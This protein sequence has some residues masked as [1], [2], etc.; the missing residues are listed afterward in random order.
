MVATE[1]APPLEAPVPPGLEWVISRC[2]EKDPM[3][4]F[5]SMAELAASLAPFADNPVQGTRST[6]RT[7]R[8]LGMRESHE[9]LNAS[10]DSGMALRD[11]QT[12]LGTSS[13]ERVGLRRP[14]VP[15][16]T[17][18]LPALG[19]AGQ[20]GASPVQGL[21]ADMG[22][23]PSASQRRLRL[24]LTAGLGLVAV[25]VVIGILAMRQP[26]G[27]ALQPATSGPPSAVPPARVDAT[28]AVVPVSPAKAPAAAERVS[29]PGEVTPAVPAA[30]AQ[31]ARP[32]RRQR[33]TEG[34]TERAAERA[35]G[36]D[37]GRAG[38]QRRETRKRAGESDDDEIFGS[39]Q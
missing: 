19:A 4:R 21:G 31:D 28:P 10:R 8:V 38:T 12:T 7:A 22:L 11:S 5:D 13:G 3:L 1:P 37:G 17:M 20:P 16:M 32:V 33:G 39:R 23:G 15:A 34:A 35:T 9:S 2:L 18:S 24:G 25:L 26:A 14:A 29:G 27:P 6:E 36:R 30:E